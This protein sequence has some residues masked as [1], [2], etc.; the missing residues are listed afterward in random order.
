MWRSFRPSV[1]QTA[2]FLLVP[3]ALLASRS[4]QVLVWPTSDDPQRAD[5]IVVYA[6]GQPNERIGVAV[7]LM[8]QGVAATLVIS[9]GNQRWG[10]GTEVERLCQEGS[11]SFDVICVTPLPDTTI[12]E[13]AL[14]GE[15][16]TKYGWEHLVVVTSDAHL[17]RA[18]LWLKRCFT[19][20]VSQVGSQS[21]GPHHYRHEWF[22]VVH[23]RLLDR[24][25]PDSHSGSVSATWIR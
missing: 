25:C 12:G 18:S 3:L 21:D 10:V 24:H 4:V 11:P 19:G 20:N 15:L 2:L 16:A 23:A 9:E 5:A 7:E 8:E 17:S 6:G 22:G 1:V 13:A 14:F